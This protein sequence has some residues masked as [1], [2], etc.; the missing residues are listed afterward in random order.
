MYA[1]A[2]LETGISEGA[3]SWRSKSE[4][5]LV[6]LVMTSGGEGERYNLGDCGVLA[7]PEGKTC[8]KFSV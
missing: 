5:R 8:C 3:P 4:D 2:D 7:K 1:D 6:D